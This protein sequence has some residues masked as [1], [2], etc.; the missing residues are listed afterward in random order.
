MLAE[1]ITVGVL[2]SFAL[3]LRTYGL[4]GT[5]DGLHGDEAIVGLEAQHILRDGWIGPYSPLALGQPAGPLYLV[6]PAV[7]VFG[8][9]AFAVRLVPAI[10]GTMTVLVLY[11]ALRARF[12]RLGG[13]IGAVMLATMGWHLLLTRTGFPVGWWPLV[14]LLAAWTLSRGVRSDSIG[15]Y[16]VAGAATAAGI[17]VYNAHYVVIG[18]FG[19]VLLGM[20]IARRNHPL[21]R[22]LLCIGAF[23]CGLVI[24]ALPMIGFASDNSNGYFQHFRAE[25]ITS[26]SEWDARDTPLA[27]G[28][29]LATRY[30]EAWMR[31]T[32]HPKG[33][34]V[35]GSGIVPILPVVLVVLSGVGMVV[36]LRS[37]RD[38]PMIW[39]GIAIIAVA[40]AGAAFT[41]NEGIAR[42]TLVMTPFLAM[43]AAIGVAGFVRF[44][45]RRG[46]WP[47]WPVAASG[48]AA[49][50]VVFCAWQG[51]VPYFTTFA[52]SPDQR[53]TYDAD[54]TDASHFMATLKPGD[55]V[56]LASDR[57][58]INYE[59]RQFLAP[60][61]QGEDIG[62]R[63]AAHRFV[64]FPARGRP[65]FILLDSFRS[66]LRALE[67]QY[68]GGT[69]VEGPS[70]DTGP[71]FVA[72]ELPKA[73]ALQ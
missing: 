10:A 31:L 72:Y 14:T 28:R 52:R 4:A 30:G 7:R 38:E 36:G 71:A 62:P 70:T 5:P 49:A 67:Q 21:Q 50:L 39:L 12:G 46:G 64:Y 6:A 33:D 44:V 55:Y 22:D 68:P 27:K 65:V 9:T 59:T 18:A 13:L 57:Q 41:N 29:L 69:A 32:I 15:W 53:W 45:A 42:R 37:R 26:T 54:F 73:A 8:N 60:H 61:V 40:P 19:L 1:G 24:V 25:S 3:F 58:S 2:V 16:A 34:G 20:L 51:A 63:D 11:L 43:F 66:D 35:D 48:V 47:G 56:Y 23:C 17:Y